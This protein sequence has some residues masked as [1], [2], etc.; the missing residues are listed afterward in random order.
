ML[1]WKPIDGYFYPYRISDQGDVQKFRDGKWMP[2]KP[3][4][5]HGA[6]RARVKMRIDKDTWKDIPVVWLMADAFFN[7]HSP[8]YAIIHR[9][10]A[11]MDCSKNN[12]KFI[13]RKEVGKLSAG[14]SRKAVMKIDRDGNVV[15]IYSSGR[16]AARKNYISRTAVWNRCM[17]RVPDPYDL[18]GYN[19]QYEDGK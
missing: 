2:C 13:P 12:L 5:S 10:G 8:E 16:E 7:G 15:E 19:Y 18:D 1:E 17:N 11:K 14:A 3:Y 9:N 6:N 4:I